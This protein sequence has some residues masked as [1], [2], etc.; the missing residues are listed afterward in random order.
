VAPHLGSSMAQNPP[1]NPHSQRT[2]YSHNDSANPLSTEN[3]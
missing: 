1:N 2:E 3:Q